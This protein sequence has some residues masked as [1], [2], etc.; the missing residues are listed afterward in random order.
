MSPADWDAASRV[1]MPLIM[2]L[3]FLGVTV[4]VIVAVMKRGLSQITH[5]DG[6]GA[7]SL[8]NIEGRLGSI[9]RRIDAVERSDSDQ[10]AGIRALRSQQDAIL[11][12][13]GLCQ[14]QPD[15]PVRQR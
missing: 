2:S 6:N 1:G 14:Q 4:P 10:M 7:P 8:S 12:Q 5:G 9:E 13:L 11:N 3:S 15:C